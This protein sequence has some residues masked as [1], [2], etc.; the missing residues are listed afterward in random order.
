MRFKRTTIE[1]RGGKMERGKYRTTCSVLGWGALDAFDCRFVFCCR[2]HRHQ[3]VESRR[4]L[5]PPQQHPGRQ[6]GGGEEGRS[7]S[8]TG[9]V[10]PRAFG[11][12]RR[13]EGGDGHDVDVDCRDAGVLHEPWFCDGGVGSVPCQER[14]Y[15]S[16]QELHRVCGF[17][18]SLFGFGLGADVWRRQSIFWD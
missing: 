1:K 15:D 14:G 12:D 3:R 11:T 18:D 2:K 5:R 17:V 6:R 4:R 8:G 10:Y 9:A 13:G 7:R 16:G